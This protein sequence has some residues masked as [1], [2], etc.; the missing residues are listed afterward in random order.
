MADIIVGEWML[1]GKD[2]VCVDVIIVGP[3]MLT[4]ELQM[5][6]ERI[7]DRGTV[8]SGLTLFCFWPMDALQKG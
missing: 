5:L 2:E 8:R 1:R 4:V 6:R 3:W 7:L